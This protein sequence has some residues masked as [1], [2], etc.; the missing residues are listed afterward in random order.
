[1]KKRLQDFPR[2]MQH[3]LMMIAGML[4]MA[5]F[6]LAEGFPTGL[7][8]ISLLYSGLSLLLAWTCLLVPGKLRWLFGCIGTTLFFGIAFWLLP[9]RG[10]Y[11]LL[12]LPVAYSALLVLTLPMGGWN[13]ED[14]LSPVWAVACAVLHL[15]VYLHLRFAQRNGESLLFDERAFSLLLTVSFLLFL[16]LAMLALNRLSL[17]YASQHRVQVPLNMRRRN[18]VLTI[19][20]F[21]FAVIM[22]ALPAIGAFLSRLWEEFTSSIARFVNW[23]GS[24]F[25]PAESAGG[26]GGGADM[27]A[28]LGAL[29]TPEPTL[30]QIIVE[31]ILF[32]LAFVAGIALLIWMGYELWQKGKRLFRW[33]WKRFEWFTSAVAKDYE[34]EVTDTRDEAQYEKT[35][36][37]QRLKKRLVRVDESKLSPKQR[38]RYRYQRLRM[39]HEEWQPSDTVRDTLPME[40]AQL[41]ERARY[42]NQTITEEEAQQFK[43]EIRWI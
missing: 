35:S 40:A 42:G 1:M 43:E 15:L 20:L 6:L 10:K 25:S 41:Y 29:E 18:K 28:S 12:I 33:L 8:S 34:D 13:R 11:Y 2:K 3:S 19:G 16:L 23:F 21:L 31:K 36:A 24:L 32:A 14:E 38:V 22:A 17:T 39:K 9:I 27:T 37:L 30:F 7:I 26:G 4:P 5:L